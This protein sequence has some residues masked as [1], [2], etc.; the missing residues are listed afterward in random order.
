MPLDSPCRIIYLILY[1]RT[2]PRLMFPNKGEHLLDEV[3]RILL[4]YIHPW[5][6]TICRRRDNQEQ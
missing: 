1:V 4:R 5:D 6:A 3:F 2:D